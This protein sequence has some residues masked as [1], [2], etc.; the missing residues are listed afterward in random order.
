M[1]PGLLAPT[2]GLVVVRGDGL[3]GFGTVQCSRV[4]VASGVIALTRVERCLLKQL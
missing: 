1:V 3:S 4:D 2:S